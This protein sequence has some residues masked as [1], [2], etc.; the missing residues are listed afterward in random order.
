M[1]ILGFL[2][3]TWQSIAATAATI[4]TGAIV[5][6]ARDYLICKIIGM[7]NPEKYI[8]MVISKIDNYGNELVYKIEV[9][10][11]KYID[12]LKKNN[13]KAGALLEK[14]LADALI[15]LGK[16]LNKDLNSAANAILDK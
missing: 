3:G 10:D 7:V 8:N 12:P 2:T 13:P 4:V 15:G 1:D 14:T 11:K 5:F 6:R 16:E 9:L